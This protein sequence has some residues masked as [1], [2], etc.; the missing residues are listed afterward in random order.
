LK[1]KIEGIVISET[2]YSETSKIINILT[3]DGIVGCMA[4]GAKNIKSNLRIGT[5]KITKAEFIILNKKDKLSTLTSVDVL[6][7]YRNIK[8]DITK[9]SYATYIIE[10]ATQVMRHNQNEDV[11]YLLLSSLDKINDNFDALTITNI[12]ELK[13][14]EYLG[15]M[16]IID[17]CASCGAKT[18]IVTLSS[19]RGGYVCKN[20]HKNERV[21]SEKT[22]KLIRMFYYVDINKI[23]KLDISSKS[24]MEIS[25]F[26]DEY[27]DRYTG[28]FLKSKILLK[29]INKVS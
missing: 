9:I 29:N 20:C 28:L 11:Y 26:L 12:L 19:S 23:S 6:S 3:K 2:P 13:Y 21:V 18:N 17:S 22:I 16:P 4:K 25:D 1:E 5:N 14:L 27:Y 10:L 15:V 7:D 8:K 24:K